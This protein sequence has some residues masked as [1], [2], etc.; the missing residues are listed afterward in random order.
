M[1]PTFILFRPKLNEAR[2]Y[3]IFLFHLSKHANLQSL[4]L[5]KKNNLLCL[6]DF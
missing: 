1:G 3:N 6:Q 5:S 4:I 2:S